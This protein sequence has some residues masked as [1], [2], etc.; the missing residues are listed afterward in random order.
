MGRGPLNTPDLSAFNLIDMAQ[1]PDII[2]VGYREA[3]KA[4]GSS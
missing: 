4:L 1:I 3:I 2:E